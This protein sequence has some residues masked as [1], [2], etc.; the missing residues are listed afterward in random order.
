M[1][2][3]P[4][5]S[6]IASRIL[7]TRLKTLMLGL[8]AGALLWAT[9]AP[10]RAEGDPPG[11]VGRI[12]EMQG[13]VSRFDHEEGRWSDAERNRPFTAGDRLST[14]GG[15]ARV[16][17]RV[18]STTLRLGP[19]TELE[20]VR[21][22]DERMAFQLHSGAL[23]L[24]IRSREVAAELEVVTNEVRLLPLRGGHFRIDRVDDTTYAGSWRGELRV[25]DSGRLT[26]STG[27]RLEL[28]REPRSRELRHVWRG[29]QDD[30]FAS[31]VMADDQRD[32]RSASARHVSPEMT[33][34]EDL[35]RWGSWDRHPDYGM[36]WYPTTVSVGWAPYRHGRWVWV[37]PW[38]WTWVDESPWGFAPFH[39]GRWV[40]WGGRW[41]WAPG[42][43]VAR[44]VYAP[45]LVAWVGGPHVSLSV[46]V[47]P[48]VGWVP[49]A[50]REVYQPYYRVSPI[51]IDRVNVHVPPHFRNRP[52]QTV[53]TGPI[54]YTNQGVP[55]AV[56]V[57]PRDV[58]SRR[59]PVA[60][61]VVQVQDVHRAPVTTAPAA[62]TPI[63]RV[64]PAPGGG[65]RANPPG[66][67][68]R[69]EPAQ[70]APGGAVTRVEPAPAM[71][72]RGDSPAARV[73]PAPVQRAEPAPVGRV[74]REA[75]DDGR[76]VRIVRPPV[77]PT[78]VQA[79][80]PPQQQ[81]Q[82]QQQPQPRQQPQPA[83]QP[84][85]VV[86]RQPAPVLAAPP[87]QATPRNAPA[88]QQV[89]PAPREQRGSDDDRKRVTP[90]HGERERQESR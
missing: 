30:A 45:A 38:G 83:Q 31:W 17:L 65:G 35:D 39:Y 11:R 62:P 7:S 19:G 63:T 20:A 74:P 15:N 14:A 61:A 44:P 85:Q 58:L 26:V 86:P 78:P 67:V 47:G 50:P 54:A 88:Q 6:R 5:A 4:S 80:P 32:E 69:V 33:G 46:T 79:V 81:Q 23:A 53:P 34:A 64:E 9:G 1:S 3:A 16:E 12:V 90:R 56:T 89:Q 25:E 55:G 40:W 8:A 75:N 84:V 82:Q 2:A 66:Q 41:C 52:P 48:T 21:L 87:P 27:Q 24:R 22:D 72:G 71:G 28:Y 73:E 77:Q 49:L 68:G 70:P 59:E 60:R 29:M 10:A 57:V 37:R 36:I 51:Y 18:G 76:N 42:N 13:H 43:Y